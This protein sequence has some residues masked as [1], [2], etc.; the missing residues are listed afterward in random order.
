MVSKRIGN[1]LV[2]TASL[3]MGVFEVGYER[4]AKWLQNCNIFL[5]IKVKDW[6]SVWYNRR[7]MGG[8]VVLEGVR[9][10][11]RSFGKI[12]DGIES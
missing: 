9:G 1:W 5:R 3:P 7:I 10:R 8:W 6:E 2:D 11:G 4:V 12:K